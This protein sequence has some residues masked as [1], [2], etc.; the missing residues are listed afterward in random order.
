VSWRRDKRPRSEDVHP[1][2]E[3]LERLL[4]EKPI[5]RGLPLG[6]LAA[7][8]ADV[9]G[10]KLAEETVPVGLERGVLDLV[11]STQA[12]A[13]QVGFLGPDIARKA[14]EVLASEAVREVRARVGSRGPQ[15]PQNRRSGPHF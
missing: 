11:V 2:G 3:I 6:R 10:P 15:K 1:I 7:R 8:W 9:V 5:A 12:W 13:A 14:N 4:A